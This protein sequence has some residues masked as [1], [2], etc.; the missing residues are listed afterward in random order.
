[1]NRL[2]SLPSL[3]FISS[4][5]LGPPSTMRS[6]TISVIALAAASGALANTEET[7]K[8]T[9]K[10]RRCKCRYISEPSNLRISRI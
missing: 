1:M 10:V 8:P 6:V 5:S 2:V 3:D 7:P 4:S 9:F